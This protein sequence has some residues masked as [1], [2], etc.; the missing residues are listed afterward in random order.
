M[1]VTKT[2][3]ATKS[4]A[5]DA[6]QVARQVTQQAGQQRADV[7]SS[8]I[9]ID[10]IGDAER[11]KVATDDRSDTGFNQ[12]SR[13]LANS[14]S[15]AELTYAITLGMS[16]QVAQN[17]IDFARAV[18]AQVVRSAVLGNTIDHA[19]DKQMIRHEGVAADAELESPSEGA[20]EGHI[21][22]AASVDTAALAAVQ[23]I[24]PAV[25]AATLKELG[26]PKAK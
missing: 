24:I 20:A 12:V 9:R 23:A 25:V 18:N 7:G 6:E 10:D 15:F 2:K 8:E 19:L 3:R 17:S 26:V 4:P 11:K 21:L 5:Q 13:L 14:Q 16:Q 1:A 22:K